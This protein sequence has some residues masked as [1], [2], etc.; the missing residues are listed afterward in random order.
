M[1]LR[2]HWSRPTSRKRLLTIAAGL[3]ERARR[4]QVLSEMA[5]DH[6]RSA[7][8]DFELT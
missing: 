6:H 7:S 3:G 8:Y 2:K 1:L 5:S 4:A